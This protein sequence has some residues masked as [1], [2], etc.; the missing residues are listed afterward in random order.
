MVNLILNG[1]V[2]PNIYNQDT[3]KNTENNL[4]I[5]GKFDVVVSHPPFGKSFSKNNFYD[6][7]NSLELLFLQ[8]FMESL[9]PEGRAAIVVPDSLL[10]QKSYVFN[11]VRKNLLENFNVHT[12]LSLP[13]GIFLPYSGAKMNVIFFDK[14]SKTSK[15]WYYELNAPFIFTKNRPVTDA[16]FKEFI[17]LYKNVERRNSTN[18]KNSESPDDWTVSFN[19]KMEFNLSAKNPNKIVDLE[20]FKP[21][22]LISQIESISFEEENYLAKVNPSIFELVKEEYYNSNWETVRLSN[23][24]EKVKNHTEISNNDIVT[25]IDL[26]S[27][28]T[29]RNKIEA[30]K[31]LTSKELPNKT[32]NGAVKGDI[33]FSLN[34]PNL[35][36]IAVI[37][38][39]YERTVVSSVFCILRPNK[40]LLSADYLFYYLLSETF[41]QFVN[42]LIKGSAFPSI[43]EKDLL[44]IKISLPPL[45]LQKKVANEMKNMFDTINSVIELQS[46]KIENL[47]L[48]QIS[49][50]QKI[51]NYKEL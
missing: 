2:T 32:K 48:L 3:L 49:I 46:K 29:Q 4:Q 24:V 36:N 40:N 50:L 17:D 42:P 44:N 16:H 34:R 26:Q 18:N 23:L 31:I 14:K 35:K 47:K 37:R 33:I 39:D 25:Y 11:E 1:I 43:S 9:G 28:N 12:I 45:D 20:L 13:G 27:I 19:E 15:I 51:Y 7:T 41:Q 10:I 22:N 6:A 21:E 8:H 30:P 38:E 5:K